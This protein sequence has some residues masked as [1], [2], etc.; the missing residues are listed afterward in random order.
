MLLVHGPQVKFKRRDQG[1]ISIA[2]MYKAGRGE[3]EEEVH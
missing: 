2:L 1:F 3:G